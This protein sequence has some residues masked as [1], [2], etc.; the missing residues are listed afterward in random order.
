MTGR[1]SV[2][3]IITNSIALLA[4]FGVVWAQ[5][6]IRVTFD[7]PPTMP[8]GS[9]SSG[10]YI[11]SESG[12]G[13]HPAGDG[14]TRRW[15]GDPLFPDNGTAY[16][17]AGYIAGAYFDYIGGSYLFNAVSVDLALYSATNL[18]PRTIQFAAVSYGGQTIATAEFTVTL[19]GQGRPAFQTFNF[20]QE[21]R[22]MHSLEIRNPGPVWSLDNLVISTIPEP[23]VISLFGLGAL[24]L[25]WSPWRKTKRRTIDTL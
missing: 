11:Y 10:W 13:A 14:F 20:P 19:D 8:P 9:S 5:G 7:G 1:C 15:S 3:R 12:V 25:G 21:F 17:Q 22:G 6:T 18:N 2:K 24:F 16:L 4:S 23:S